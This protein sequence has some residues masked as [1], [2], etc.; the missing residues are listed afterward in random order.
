MRLKNAHIALFVFLALSAVNL[1][2]QGVTGV[3]SSD[4][5]DLTLQQVGTRVTGTYP[6]AEGRIEGTISGLTVSGWWYQSNGKGRFVFNFSPDASAFTGKWSYE[7]AEPSS[8]WNGKRISGGPS[9]LSPPALV[10]PGPSYAIPYLAGVYESDFGKVTLSQNGASVTGTYEHADGRVEGTLS[11]STVSGWW[12]QSNGK[13]R[14]VFVFNSDAS[15]FTGKWSYESAEPS[16]QWN[17]RRIGE[18]TGA[19]SGGGTPSQSPNL[20]GSKEIFNNWNKAAV[21]NGPSSPTYFYLGAPSTVARIITYHWNDMR[22]KLPG[23]IG[24]RGADGKVYGPWPAQGSGGTGGAQNV[25]WT[26]Y[27]NLS[28]PAGIYQILDGDPG[29]WSYNSGSFGSG[30]AAV[31]AY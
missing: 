22:G 3:Y 12:Y 27:P 2:A 11:G 10:S 21:Y 15:A 25:N 4:F 13:G 18:A 30:F 17:G 29:S 9:T 28:L 7:S 23:T 8:Q 19:P 14:F 20:A 31:L 6:H 1:L 26:V 5:G 16:G 24:L